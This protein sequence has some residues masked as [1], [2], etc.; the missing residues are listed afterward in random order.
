[1]EVS[2][3]TTNGKGMQYAFRVLCRYI[4]FFQWIPAST[5]KW[6]NE[7]LKQCFTA[8]GTWFK[9]KRWRY[10]N[11]IQK[12]F[13]FLF[14][15]K[16]D[17]GKRRRS[18]SVLWQKP[19]HP[20]KSPKSNVTTEKRQQNLDYTTIADRLR[21]VSWSNSSHPTGEVKPAY[22]RSTFTLTATAVLSKGHTFK[23]V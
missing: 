13:D 17:K 14:R 6:Y 20:Q 1:M 16:C 9:K 23:N 4:L 7:S 19:L 15:I 22:E 18:D 11:K 2:I 5:P 21:M 10:S 8:P 12:D 3:P